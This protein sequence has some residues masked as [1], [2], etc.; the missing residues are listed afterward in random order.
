MENQGSAAVESTDV[1]VVGGG[2]AGVTAAR[3]LATAGH[4]VVLLEARDRLGGRT[5]SRE[6]NGDVIELG[7]M[8][9]HYLQPFVWSELVRA[10]SELRKLGLP[11]VTLFNGGGGPMEM[12]SVDRAGLA[13]AWRAYHAHAL[14]SVPN[15]YAV[16][17]SDT[18]HLAIDKQTMSE[19]LA[20]LE[21]DPLLHGRMAAALTA[22]ANGP[23]DQAGAMFPNRIFAMSGFSVEALEAT[24]TDLV[25]AAGTGQL[26][27]AIASQAQFDIRLESPVAKVVRKDDGVRVEQSDGQVVEARAVVL[28][29]PLNVLSHMEFA[30]ALP[31]RT[32]AAVALQQ[33]SSGFKLLIKAKASGKR[34]DAS[35][36]G[37]V[38]AHL[39]TD[40]T[41]T[42]GSQ[43]L[44][45]FGP[46]ARHIDGASIA[47][48]QS[49]VDALAPGLVVDDFLWHDW[50]TDPYSNGTWSVHRPSWVT[51][52]NEALAAPVGNLFFAG[53]DIAQ[54]WVGHIDGAIETG[55]TAARHV[56]Q[57]LRN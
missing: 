54:G 31:Q 48:V 27:S 40:R 12:D 2:F 1:I 26:I 29:L 24:T 17:L 28:A 7:G 45:A 44:V 46:N 25:L 50:T 53:G 19:R 36:A 14:E 37:T 35:G 30:P 57:Y 39:L 41:Y 20:D 47:D 22:W 33:V 23:I 6:W 9:V 16:N 11:D 56:R 5:H 43:L 38:I 4:Q 3:E 13:Q 10:G 42:D 52:H 21:L 15:Q 32:A 49:H 18:R 8:W 51:E 34:I 55:F